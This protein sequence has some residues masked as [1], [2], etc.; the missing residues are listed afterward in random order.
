MRTSIAIACLVGAL[1]WL[2]AGCQSAGQESPHHPSSARPA[3]TPAA[4]W[5]DAPEAPDPLTGAPVSP[6]LIRNADLTLEVEDYAAVA[7][8]VARQAEE[9]NGCWLIVDATWPDDLQ[10][11]GLGFLR[12][13]EDTPKARKDFQ[14]KVDKGE[15]LEADSIEAL[16]E[17]MKVPV[18]SFKKTI[19]RYNELVK[20][21]CD[22]DFGKRPDRMTAVDTS[23]FYA[24][25]SPNPDRPM[26]IFGGLLTNDRLQALHC[27]KSGDPYCATPAR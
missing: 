25:W 3:T 7:L 24:H 22:L 13:F 5:T 19:N 6:L 17:K 23:P 12:E 26:L 10:Y 20:G 14:D 18:D 16:A 27:R 1:W 15:I 9:Q 11:M 8:A 21:G 2:A 4:P